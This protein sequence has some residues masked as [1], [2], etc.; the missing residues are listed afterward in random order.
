MKV[1]LIDADGILA[2][3]DVGNTKD[4]VA[5]PHAGD[6]V[7]GQGRMCGHV[8]QVAFHYYNECVCVRIKRD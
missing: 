6:Y 8:T 1:M 3:Q 5:I 7:Y 2:S 4:G